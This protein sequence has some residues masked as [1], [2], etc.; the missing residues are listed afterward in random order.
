MINPFGTNI[1]LTKVFDIRDKDVRWE[2]FA[3]LKE[4]EYENNE[5]YRGFINAN[6][7]LILVRT[8]YDKQIFL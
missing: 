1:K 3:H 2:D 8:D 4:S 6:G 7:E 5:Y